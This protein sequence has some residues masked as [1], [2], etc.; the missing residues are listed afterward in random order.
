MVPFSPNTDEGTLVKLFT[1]YCEKKKIPHIDRD[2][3]GNIRI[4]KWS[5][6]ADSAIATLKDDPN[7]KAIIFEIEDN[8]TKLLKDLEKQEYLCVSNLGG[9]TIWDG[10]P[11]GAIFKVIRENDTLKPKRTTDYFPLE[12]FIDYAYEIYKGSDNPQSCEIVNEALELQKKYTEKDIFHIIACAFQDMPVSTEQTPDSYL[13]L[14]SQKCQKIK[15][16]ED[17][18]KIMEKIIFSKSTKKKEKNLDNILQKVHTLL[19]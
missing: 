6:S 5:H 3:K 18:I 17:K 12:K 1:D 13:Q 4:E 16:T 9:I 10:I 19:I 7:T 8:E 15:H 11:C 14:L 2:A